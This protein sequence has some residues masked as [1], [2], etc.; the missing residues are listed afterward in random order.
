MKVRVTMNDGCRADLRDWLGRLP[1]APEDRY[2]L[3]AV[4]I[5]ELKR[6]LARTRGHPARSEFRDEPSPPSHWWAYA[7][8][9]VV[10]YVIRDTGFFV[11]SRHI[12]VIRIVPAFPL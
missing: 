5:E 1:G 10:R 9:C 3:L 2:A 11:T 4:A 7:S 8:E 6:E 12:E